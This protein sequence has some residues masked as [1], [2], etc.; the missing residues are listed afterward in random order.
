MV[1]A[2]VGRRAMEQ[3]LSWNLHAVRKHL[4]KAVT[5]GHED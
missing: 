5:A 1:R 2:I 4:A 3:D